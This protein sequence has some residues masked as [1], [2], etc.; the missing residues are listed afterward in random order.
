MLSDF[1]LCLRCAVSLTVVKSSTLGSETLKKNP[2]YCI[3][4]ACIEPSCIKP[5]GLPTTT[6]FLLNPFQNPRKFGNQRMKPGTVTPL[7]EQIAEPTNTRSM[8]LV[9]THEY[10][11]LKPSKVKGMRCC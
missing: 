3:R 6:C 10:L 4:H 5:S 7:P 1:G 11:A 8:S 2:V 9:G